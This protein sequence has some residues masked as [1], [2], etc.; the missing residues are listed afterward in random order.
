[1]FAISSCFWLRIF[2]RFLY[3]NCLVLGGNTQVNTDGSVSLEGHVYILNSIHSFV[4]SKT[5]KQRQSNSSNTSESFDLRS[6]GLSVK[7]M[8]GKLIDQNVESIM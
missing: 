3:W 2:L 1:M 8:S 4:V 6:G 5:S 7:V